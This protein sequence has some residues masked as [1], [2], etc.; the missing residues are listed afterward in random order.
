M[1]R[2]LKKN[3]Y[4]VQFFPSHCTIANKTTKCIHV[5]GVSKN[6]LY[7]VNS[8]A[9]FYFSFLSD[10]TNVT[11]DSDF[12]LWYHRLGHVLLPNIKHISCFKFSVPHSNTLCVSYP[13]SKATRLPFSNS[14]SHASESFELLHI[15]IWDRIR[16]FIKQNTDIFLHL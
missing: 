10:N 11:T 14:T 1:Q 2:L 3:N 6:G 8:A 15:D 5:V 9:P 13:M 12:S 4:D 7:Y 16:S